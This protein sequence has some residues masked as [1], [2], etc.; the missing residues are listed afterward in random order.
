MTKPTCVCV[1]R[2]E[3]FI[4]TARWRSRTKRKEKLPELDERK[5]KKE[6][7]ETQTMSLG[8]E[9][10]I[11]TPKVSCNEGKRKEKISRNHKES[12]IRRRGEKI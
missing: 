12:E 9:K 1:C 4:D 11:V 3:Q 2:V 6:V 8:A 7:I 10:K 5:K